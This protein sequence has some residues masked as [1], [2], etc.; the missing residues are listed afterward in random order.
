METAVRTLD[1]I[2][3][4]TLGHA[5]H[6]IRVLGHPLRLRILETLED[7]PRPVMELVRA[8]GATQAMVSQQ[9]AILRGAGVVGAR[10]D[11]PRVYYQII[12][13]KVGRILACIRECDVPELAEPG[14]APLTI[15][16]GALAAGGSTS[17]RADG[18]R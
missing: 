17:H 6:V 8:V 14:G 9:L 1:R 18:S 12:E 2:D 4:Q 16:M 13:P 10:R 3:E 5:A 15:V 11:G 7:G